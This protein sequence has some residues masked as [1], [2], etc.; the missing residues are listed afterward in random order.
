MRPTIANDWLQEKARELGFDAVGASKVE[1]P[2]TTFSHFE[3]WLDGG[4]YGTM[5]YLPRSRDRVGGSV[6]RESTP[7][8]RRQRHRD[9]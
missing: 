3:K 2:P 5:T 6:P 4:L 9:N 1:I 8:E 7:Y